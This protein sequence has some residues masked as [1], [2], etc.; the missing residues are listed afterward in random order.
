MNAP[1]PSFPPPG[2]SDVSSTRLRTWTEECR[3]FA[4]APLPPPRPPPLRLLFQLF[5]SEPRRRSQSRRTSWCCAVPK[6]R[7]SCLSISPSG[8]TR[9]FVRVCFSGGGTVNLVSASLALQLPFKKYGENG[10]TSSCKPNFPAA[11]PRRAE[12]PAGKPAEAA[13]PP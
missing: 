8:S 7:A 3:G 9:E 4:Q 6:T 11:D 5:A 12:I 2:S 13:V 10:Q 1:L